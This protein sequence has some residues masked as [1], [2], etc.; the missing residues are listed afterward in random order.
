MT[1]TLKDKSLNSSDLYVTYGT[2]IEVSNTEMMVID[3]SSLRLTK[4]MNSMESVG[5][6]NFACMHGKNI[7]D[8]SDVT[9]DCK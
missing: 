8:S 7:V 9:I 1:C 4:H 3:S 6:T 2:E 5:L